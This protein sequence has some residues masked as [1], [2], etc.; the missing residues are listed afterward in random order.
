MLGVQDLR[1]RV[2]GFG[3]RGAGAVCIISVEGFRVE[4]LWFRGLC[5]GFRI[6]D[7]AFEVEG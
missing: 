4:V 3:V 1:I 7:F 2:D 5:S 6:S